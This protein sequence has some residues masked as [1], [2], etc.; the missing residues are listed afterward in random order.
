MII[1]IIIIIT[2][3]QEINNARWQRKGNKNYTKLTRMFQKLD[4]HALN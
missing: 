2:L 1:I 3:I 4:L